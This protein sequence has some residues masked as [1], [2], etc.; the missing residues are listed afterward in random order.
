MLG[1]RSCAVN[2]MDTQ[3]VDRDAR[4]RLPGLLYLFVL[5]VVTPLCFFGAAEVGQQLVEFLADRGHD[6]KWWTV[7]LAMPIG[8]LLAVGVCRLTGAHQ[9]DT[10]AIT[11]MS[12][13]LTIALMVHF[14]ASGLN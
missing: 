10:R 8:P 9:S 5:V 6:A 12:T 11:L 14:T 7:Y 3:S 4:R 13:L 1:A 2:D